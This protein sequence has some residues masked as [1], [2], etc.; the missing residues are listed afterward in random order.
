MLDPLDSALMILTE[1]EWREL[2][3]RDGKLD[4]LLEKP[5]VRMA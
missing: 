1:H 4:G 2:Y 3:R 5:H